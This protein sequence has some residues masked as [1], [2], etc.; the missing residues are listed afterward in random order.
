VKKKPL[1]PVLLAAAAALAVLAVGAV[2]PIWTVPGR[3]DDIDNPALRR[4]IWRSGPLWMEPA[5]LI[6]PS[7]F[8]Q[9]N[10]LQLAVLAGA[11][12]GAGL[13]AY[14]AATPRKRADQVDDYEEKPDGSIPDGRA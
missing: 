8:R 10:M 14:R 7:P 11:M 5:G 9:R 12:F 4:I 6:E 13:L 2:L 1:R 3:N